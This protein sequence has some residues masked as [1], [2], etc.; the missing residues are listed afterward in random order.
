MITRCI[1]L[2]AFILTFVAAAQS[3]D[4]PS[5]KKQLQGTW[6]VVSIEGIGMKPFPPETLKDASV[7]FAGDKVTISIDGDKV[8]REFKLDP[9]KKPKAIDIGKG[10]GIYHLDGDNLKL[11]WD[12][13]GEKRPEEFS[14]KG[15]NRGSS[16]FRLLVLKREK[17]K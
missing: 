11:C 10:P 13:M 8:E 14:I 4:S 1:L 5:E 17:T 12:A 6:K 9:T 16:D 15:S 3:G 2:T 7:V